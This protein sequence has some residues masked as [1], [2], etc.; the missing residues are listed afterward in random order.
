MKPSTAL[1]PPV[2]A[3]APHQASAV[4]WNE[5]LA[6]REFLLRFAGRKLHDPALAEDV[7]HDVFEAVIA[8]RA[9]FGGQSALRTWLAGVLKHKIVDLIRQRSGLDGLA[10]DLDGEA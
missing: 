8:G 1:T 2:I 9:V 3:P 10:E 6:H 5:L 4:P 7:V